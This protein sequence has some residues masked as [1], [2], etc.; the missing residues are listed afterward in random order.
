MAALGFDLFAEPDHA[1]TTVTAVRLPDGLEWPAF[2]S[3]LRA[4]GLIVAGGQGALAGRIFRVG[5]LG[6]VYEADILS[7]LDVIESTLAGLGWPV[8]R[9]RALTAA[10]RA[11]DARGGPDGPVSPSPGASAGATAAP[12]ERAGAAATATVR[13]TA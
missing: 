7:A 1:S 5:H 12:A 6:S 11:A 2:N 3:A 9:G 4:R 10:L 8:E 13:P